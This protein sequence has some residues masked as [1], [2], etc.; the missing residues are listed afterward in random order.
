VCC[1][2]AVA[3]LVNRGD[4]RPESRQSRSVRRPMWVGRRHC[5][6]GGACRFACGHAA[7]LAGFTL[8]SSSLLVR[9]VASDASGR[10]LIRYENT[11]QIVVTARCDVRARVSDVSSVY[12]TRV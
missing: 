6:Y 11:V 4:A 9:R 5:G 12:N 7:F 1:A 10:T 3:P 2:V 8:G